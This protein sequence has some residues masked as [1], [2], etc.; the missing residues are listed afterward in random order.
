MEDGQQCDER[1]RQQR[2]SQAKGQRQAG[3]LAA[4][5]LLFPRPRPATP[6]V[7]PRCTRPRELPQILVPFRATPGSGVARRPEAKTA[8][9]L[10]RCVCQISARRRSFPA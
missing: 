5:S 9:A 4:R 3:T 7:Q 2:H 6:L 8:R 1:E 10:R